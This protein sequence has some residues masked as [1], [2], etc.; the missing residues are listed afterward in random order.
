[1]KSDLHGIIY[2]LRSEPKLGALVSNRNSASIPFCGRYR[3]I[4]FALSAMVNAGVRD[5]GVIMERDYQS[6]LDHLSG[7]KDWGL[8]RRTGGLRLLP[9][10][11]LPEA[12]S[13]HF[14][15]CM[16]A[17]RSVRSYIEEIGQENVVLSSG[18]FVTNVDVAAA[19]EQHRVSGADITAVC[20]TAQPDLDHHRFVVD[21][22][23]FSRRMIFS[24]GG[25][26]EGL[27]S[28]EMYI[29]KKELLL[30]LMDYCSDGVRVHFHRD[31]LAH[32]LSQGGQVGIY[33]HRGYFR[34]I[35]SVQNYYEASMD[36]LEPAVMNQL[37]P[38]R[39]PIRTKERA[40]VSTYYGEAA[41]VKNSLVA[42]GCYIEGELENCVLFRGVRIAKGVKLK[43]CVIM[44]DTAVG[45]NAQLK[46]VISDKDCVV[47]PGCFL[48]G[49]ERLPILVPKGS[50]V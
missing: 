28:T 44:Q 26:G 32:Y 13:G 24:Q 35:A 49:S 37:F 36:M 20:T 30:S 1:M 33:V 25:A 15:G 50:T 41:Q 12:H 22:D 21:A 10:F 23:G 9:P 42:D 16:E 19:A 2:T 46:C 8:S 11:G 29:L 39:R 47:T 45:E 14:G 38:A 7:G 18:D 6:L 3:L 4:D 34:R 17:L 43:N 40:E 31:A 5:V 48:S 27:A